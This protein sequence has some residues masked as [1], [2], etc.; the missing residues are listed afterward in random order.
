MDGEE[1]KREGIR[2]L[3]ALGAIL[4]FCM[5][6]VLLFA[7][8]VKAASLESG[9]IPPVNR[10]IKGTAIF[11]GVLLFVKES[12]GWRQGLIVGVLTVVLSKLLF[13]C[14]A[15]EFSWEWTFWL[16]LLFGGAIGVI[17]GVIAVNLHR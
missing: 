9:V 11:L 10:L 16:E 14:I 5:A 17:S 1:L 15:L 6:A 2:I 3:K 4:L 8:I 7:F 13:S 12:G